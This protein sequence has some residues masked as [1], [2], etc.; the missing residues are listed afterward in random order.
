MYFRAI[1][2]GAL[3]SVVGHELT[4]GFDTEGLRIYSLINLTVH[5][6]KY[7]VMY[8]WKFWNKAFELINCFKAIQ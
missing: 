8:F 5:Y 3:G 7:N 1:D 6:C 2:Y 4:H